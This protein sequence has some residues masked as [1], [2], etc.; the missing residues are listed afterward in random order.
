M[1]E[2]MSAEV[3]TPRTMFGFS[4]YLPVDDD[5]RLDR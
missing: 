2:A 5:P 4:S 1:R 3:F